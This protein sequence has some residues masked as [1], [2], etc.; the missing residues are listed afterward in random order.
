[1]SGRGIRIDIN[2]GT[3]LEAVDLDTLVR[4]AMAALGVQRWAVA[5]AK[6]TIDAAP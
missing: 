1:M 6:V 2:L 5:S 3:D 4:E